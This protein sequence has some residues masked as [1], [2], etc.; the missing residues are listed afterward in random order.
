HKWESSSDEDRGYIEFAP[1]FLIGEDPP[2]QYLIEELLPSGVIA[3]MHGDPRTRKSW[4]ALD[5]AIALATGTPAFS[6]DRFRVLKPVTVLYSSQEDGRRDVRIRAKALLRGR[7]IDKFPD[8]LAF[9][10][11]KGINLE[12]HEWQ[13]R[14]IRDVQHFGF[15]A[16][17]F[18]PIRR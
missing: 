7:G 15:R 5:M 3:L 18:D 6:L 10:V 8:T 1:V 13:E 14:L 11:F 12:F 2:I 16:V 9:S 4:A 17:F